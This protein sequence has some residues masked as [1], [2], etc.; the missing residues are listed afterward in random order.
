M[1]YKGR[2]NGGLP[3]T[4]LGEYMDKLGEKIGWLVFFGRDESCCQ[5]TTCMPSLQA[6]AAGEGYLLYVPSAAYEQKTGKPYD[7][8][9]SYP[10]ETYSNEKGWKKQAP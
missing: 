9:P 3:P 10:I 8:S 4:Q 6:T 1:G 2:Q 7:Y 5:L